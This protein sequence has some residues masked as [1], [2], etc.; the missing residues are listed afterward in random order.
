MTLLLFSQSTLAIPAFSRQMNVECSGCHFQH[1]PK[2]NAFGRAFKANGFSMTTRESLDGDNLSIAPNLN[3]TLFVKS[4]VVNEEPADRLVW[5]IPDE[6]A[7]LVGGR[8]AEGIGG[9]VEWGGPLLS[10]KVS[11]TRPLGGIS[12]GVTVFATDAIGPGYGFELLNTGIT[13]NLRPFEQS[14]R[15]ISGNNDNLLVADAA[16]GL[17]FHVSNSNWFMAVTLFTPDSVAAGSTAMDADADM[18]NYVRAA[19]IFEFGESEL[20]LGLGAISG[21]PRS[22]RIAVPCVLDEN[23]QTDCSGASPG[24]VYEQSTH[25]QFVDMQFQGKVAQRNLSVYLLYAAGEPNSADTDNRY[26][27]A[28]LEE[29][30]TGWGLDTEYS[31]TENVHLLLSFGQHN[32]GTAD[33]TATNQQGIGFYWRIA[34]NVTLQPMLENFAGS[35]DGSTKRRSSITLE[36]AW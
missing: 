35:L 11:F 28:S 20:A 12:A 3:A 22:H 29:T 31:L 25:A 36:T 17:A 16:T 15:P 32:N 9:V 34:Q 13:R 26:G 1:F 19:Y 14:A 8:L 10:G 4:K 7:I 21:N 30:P 6:A 5:G 24:G 23:G 27:G 2:L 18:A 33:E